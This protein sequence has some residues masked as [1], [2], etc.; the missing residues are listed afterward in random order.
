[1]QGAELLPVL[2]GGVTSAD[3][4]PIER[5]LIPTEV[6]AAVVAQREGTIIT[7]KV[8]R[9]GSSEPVA[10]MVE[11]FVEDPDRP[12]DWNAVSSMASSVEGGFSFVVETAGRY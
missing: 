6:P 2:Q 9:Y 8:L 12:R 10:A 3:A 4:M 11:L 7:G 1:M 5:S